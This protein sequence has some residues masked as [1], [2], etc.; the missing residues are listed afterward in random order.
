MSDA[1]IFGDNC[2]LDMLIDGEYYTVL[3]QADFKFSVKQEVIL[4]TTP[5]SGLFREKTTRFSEG[6]ASCSGLTSTNN[7]VVISFFYMAQESIRTQPQTIR[8]KYEDQDGVTKQ[9]SGTAIIVNCELGTPIDDFAEA[10]IEFEFSG[11]FEIE[12]VTVPTFS[13]SLGSDTW[14]T[15]EGQNYISGLSTGWRN[16]TQYSLVGKEIIEVDRSGS[17]YDFIGNNMTPGN[18]QCSWNTTTNRLVFEYDFNAGETV[19][20]I[21]K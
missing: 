19:F 3:C 13:N 1:V 17:Q 4:I 9:I 7:G 18:R 20:V 5:N 21:W 16:G 15:T 8:L 10:S 12:E 6:F 2:S 11:A 14:E